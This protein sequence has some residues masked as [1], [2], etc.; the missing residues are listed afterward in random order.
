MLSLDT[1][2]QEYNLVEMQHAAN[3]DSNFEWSTLHASAH[4]MTEK[5]NLKINGEKAEESAVR[6]E[7]M[8]GREKLLCCLDVTSSQ[9][10]SMFEMK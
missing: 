6:I 8:Y 9:Y 4:Q 1:N 7:N 5:K 2:V 10:E 3:I